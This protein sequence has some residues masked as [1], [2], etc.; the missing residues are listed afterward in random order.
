MIKDTSA[1]MVSEICAAANEVRR[2]SSGQAWGQILIGARYLGF[3]P[4]NCCGHSRM[5]SCVPITIPTEL[6][7]TFAACDRD[8]GDGEVRDPGASALCRALPLPCLT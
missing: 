6:M 7:T 4:R 8:A 3:K 5:V 2:G 1:P